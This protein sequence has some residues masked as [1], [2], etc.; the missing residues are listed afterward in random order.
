[1]HVQLPGGVD[2]TERIVGAPQVVYWTGPQ[3]Q[4]NHTQVREIPD[5]GVPTRS[6]RRDQFAVRLG[7]LSSTFLTKSVAVVSATVSGARK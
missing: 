3:R 4:R 7:D 2:V 5:G 1:M 6:M